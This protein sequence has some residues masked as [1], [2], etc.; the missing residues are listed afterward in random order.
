[1]RDGIIVLNGSD[2]ASV[3]DVSV[4]ITEIAPTL[5]HLIKSAVPESMDS[6]VRTDL[7]LTNRPVKHV[8]SDMSRREETT[9]SNTDKDDIKQRL[10]NLGYLENE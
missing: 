10:Q 9:R 7:L 3:D 2:F 1:M 8:K 6:T 5:V 4:D